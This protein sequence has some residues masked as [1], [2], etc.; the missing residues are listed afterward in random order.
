MAPLGTLIEQKSTLK[1]HVRQLL[2]WR[3]KFKLTDALQRRI[4]F[5][6]A[7]LAIKLFNIRAATEWRRSSI[8]NI[9]SEF[10]VP[11][12][13]IG[14]MTAK[15]EVETIAKHFQVLQVSSDEWCYL[16]P[17]LVPDTNSVLLCPRCV[18]SPLEY[19]CSIA[20]CHDY[21][22][23]SSFPE[24]SKPL[25]NS[26]ELMRLFRSTININ[27]NAISGHCIYF[28]SDSPPV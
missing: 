25:E 1:T 24:L 16:N 17:E 21:R 26:V 22:I 3:K 11:Q 7:C 12:S 15:Y 5:G 8:K 20:R 6:Y 9:K 10:K 18:G 19:S 23:T 28:S 13:Y 2:C 14:E 4:L 27:S